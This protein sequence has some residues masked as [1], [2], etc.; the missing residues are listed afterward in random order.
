MAVSILKSMDSIAVA[1]V[2]TFVSWYIYSTIFEF[3]YLKGSIKELFYL[4]CHAII[5]LIASRYF[6]WFNGLL[7]YASIMLTVF[8]VF[9]SQEFKQLLIG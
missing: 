6:E 7:V 3:D 4:I 9:Y 8:L 1:M 5:F 2:L